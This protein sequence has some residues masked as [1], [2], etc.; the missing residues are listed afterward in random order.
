MGKFSVAAV[1]L[2]GHIIQKEVIIASIA[3]RAVNRTV[4]ALYEPVMAIAA[5]IIVQEESFLAGKTNRAIHT[6]VPT[7]VHHIETFSARSFTINKN[8]VAHL[9]SRTYSTSIIAVGTVGYRFGTTLTLYVLSVKSI[10]TMNANQTIQVAFST[11]WIITRYFLDWPI[12]YFYQ[13]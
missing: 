11:V 6:T 4:I 7:P 5:L 9:A 1:A 8:I 3:H 12:S 2:L 13:F 10:T